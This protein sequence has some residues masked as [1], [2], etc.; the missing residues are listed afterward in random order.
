LTLIE[1]NNKH[2]LIVPTF[3]DKLF[4]KLLFLKTTSQ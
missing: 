3:K 1:K 2:Y 4:I